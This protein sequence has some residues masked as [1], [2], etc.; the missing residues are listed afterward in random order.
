MVET[1]KARSPFGRIRSISP[2]GESTTKQVR[3]TIKQDRRCPVMRRGVALR[4]SFR[5]TSV[6][7]LRGAAVACVCAIVLA[8]CGSSG[9]TASSA[10]SQTPT[11]TVGTRP[12]SGVGTVLV[13]SHGMTLYTFTSGG[14]PVP[15]TGPCRERVAAAARACRLDT[16]GRHGCAGPGGD[17]ARAGHR[18][19]APAL[20]VRGGQR[21]WPGQ[22]S[23][24]PQLRWRVAC[25]HG[26]C[27]ERRQPRH[28][29]VEQH[30]RQPLRLLIWGGPRR[31]AGTEVD[32]G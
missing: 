6:V 21:S 32:R 13:D 8:G 10:K 26:R 28:D 9:G 1:R 18:E 14:R 17:G 15:C 4:C 22:R 30:A 27:T 19:F 5:P 12:V 20:P 11:V 31:G 25:R 3:S 2:P 29:A 24:R 23:R 7:F 16:A